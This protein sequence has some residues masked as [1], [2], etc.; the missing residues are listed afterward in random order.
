MALIKLGAIVTD[1]KGKVGGHT[2]SN[3]LGGNTLA[4]KQN[5]GLNQL[6]SSYIT[7]G[8]NNERSILPAV[9]MTQMAQK[10]RTLTD[11]QR[12]AWEAA[13]VNYPSLS[14][15]GD[16]KQTKGYNLFVKINSR[17][18]QINVSPIVVPPT[19]S[20]AGNQNSFTCDVSVASGITAAWTGSLT[21]NYNLIIEATP[22]ISKG[23]GNVA[24]QFKRIAIV[25]DPSATSYNFTSEYLDIYGN[26]IL[27][28]RMW[29]RF[30]IISTAD[31]TQ[32]IPQVVATVVIA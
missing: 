20:I 5:R 27:G 16:K 4:T 23:R 11:H 30:T 21:S 32:S 10:W 25:N 18:S 28:A 7:N 14:K 22:S 19:P 1:I 2:F 9:T 29:S 3:S 6:Q 17:L 13:S 26:V 15:F 31:A 12:S 24:S 8:G